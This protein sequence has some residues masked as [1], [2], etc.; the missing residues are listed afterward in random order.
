LTLIIFVGFQNNTL[1]QIECMTLTKAN[2][3]YWRIGA[4]QKKWEKFNLPVF[5]GDKQSIRSLNRSAAVSALRQ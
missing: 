5:G 4:S 1:Q 2:S 3:A